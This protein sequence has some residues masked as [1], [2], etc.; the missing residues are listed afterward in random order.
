MEQDDRQITLE[1][2]E[3]EIQREMRMPEAVG[4]EPPPVEPK[5]EENPARKPF[6]IKDFDSPRDK[7]MAV[8]THAKKLSEYIFVITEKSPKKL[9]WSIVSRLQNA[10]VE[11]VENL[12]HANFERDDE[13]R[14]A[15]QKS[16]A[17]G[18]KILDFYSETARKKQAITIRQTEIIA[19]QIAETTKLL[20][21][22]IKSTKRKTT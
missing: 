17:V 19:R 13:K 20:N 21:G 1:E 8:F 5:D 14:T 3:K 7:E 6:R 22:W 12:Y 10:S 2:V 15:Y 4:L 18:L 11:I 9:R 16:A